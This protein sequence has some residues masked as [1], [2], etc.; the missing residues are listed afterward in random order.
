[1]IK[2]IFFWCPN[3][4]FIKKL[5]ILLLEHV[6]TTKLEF[7]FR[8]PKYVYSYHTTRLFYTLLSK[9]FLTP[10]VWNTFGSHTYFQHRTDHHIGLILLS[11]NHNQVTCNH[12][13]ASQIFI[14]FYCKV[15]HSINILF[16]GQPC[17]RQLRYILFSFFELLYARNK[18]LSKKS[19]Y[20]AF[21]QVTIFYQTG[22][23]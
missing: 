9:T 18:T 22:N 19:Q 21:L 20:Q 17:W 4:F 13:F 12:L 11:P 2:S 14:H 3:H 23:I 6:H 8:L 10:F 7:F 1:M 16:S 15:S 5:H